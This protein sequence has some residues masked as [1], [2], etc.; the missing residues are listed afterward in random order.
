[1]NKI[2]K[3]LIDNHLRQ[4]DIVEYLGVSRPYM[5]QVTNGAANL[6]PENLERLINNDKGWSVEALTTEEPESQDEMTELA[7]LRERVKYL[8]MIVDEKERTIQLLSPHRPYM[9]GKIYKT[10]IIN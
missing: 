8:E 10:L 2:K 5:S 4:V 3:F 1:M 7:V 9:K 6:S